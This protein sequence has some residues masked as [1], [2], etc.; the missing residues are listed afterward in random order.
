MVDA[1]LVVCLGDY[2]ITGILE[3]E[4]HAILLKV[5]I[6]THPVYLTLATT[7]SF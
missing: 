3:I 2:Y 5:T 6:Y 1:T 7:L 4:G